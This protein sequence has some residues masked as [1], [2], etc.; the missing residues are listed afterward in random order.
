MP[1]KFH[2]IQKARKLKFCLRFIISVKNSNTQLAQGTYELSATSY[3]LAKM[4]FQLI[5]EL[6]TLCSTFSGC[7]APSSTTTPTTCDKQTVCTQQ[8]S[9]FILSIYIL[10]F[11]AYF[12]TSSRARLNT[13]K[14]LTQVDIT[15]KC[16]KSRQVFELNQGWS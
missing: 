10:A 8:H 12:M 14:I 1:T 3:R 13:H 4:L 15:F 16:W 6:C 7:K 2:T 5:R 11:S 9:R